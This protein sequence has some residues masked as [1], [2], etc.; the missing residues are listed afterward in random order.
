MVDRALGSINGSLQGDPAPKLGGPLDAN[1]QPIRFTKGGDLASASPLVID[2]D[3]NSFDVT[4]TTGFS[5]MT[6]AAGLWFILQ[7]DENLTMTDGAP[8]D[9]G[10]ADIQTAVGDRGLFHAVAA[11]TVVLVSYFRNS[12]ASRGL[13]RSYLTGLKLSRDA[14][15]TDHDINILPGECRDSTNKHDIVLTSEITKMLGPSSADWVV[16]D[17]AGGLD[18]TESSAGTPDASTWYHLHLIRRNDTGVVDALASESATSPSLPTGYDVFRRIGSVLM[19]SSANI[20]AFV[21]DG[22]YFRHVTKLMQSGSAN[23][24]TN[25]VT[26]VVDTPL[27]LSVIA[28]LFAKIHSV[29]TGTSILYASALDETDS[30]PSETAAPLG[31]SPGT[32]TGLNSA[33]GY[34][35]IRTNTSSQIRTRLSA[36]GANDIVRI[37]TLGW[38]D[39]RGRDD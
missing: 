19:D 37:V 7:F 38:I 16:G 31:Y 27:G 10:G 21:Q 6:V 11:D 3:G 23:P 20:L 28:Q 8:L 33:E 1:S 35:E 17:D 2:T 14:G 9:L 25:A 15:D 39:R 4:G 32:G 5:A 29:T 34:N 36:S 22:D 18:G 24:G 26:Q 30:A 12:A 13:S